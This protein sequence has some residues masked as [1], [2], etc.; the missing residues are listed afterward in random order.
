MH[1]QHSAVSLRVCTLQLYALLG[2]VQEFQ[3]A[4]C[5]GKPWQVCVST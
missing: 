4:K 3:E 2:L 5:Q 1:G